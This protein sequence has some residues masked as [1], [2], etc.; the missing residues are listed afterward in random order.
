MIDH[1][2]TYAT[3]FERTRAF[4]DAALGPL[5][6]TRNMER[7]TSQDP[8][9][10]TRRLVAYGPPGR[11]VFWVVET[12]EAATPRHIAFV[13]PSREAVA[14]FH[15]GALQHGGKDNGGP[16]LRAHYH[17]DYYGAFVLDPDGNNVEA[18]I[19]HT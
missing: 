1:A 5:G 19:H 16:G 11:Y 6:Y 7:Q 9:W 10:P 13:A 17:P 4:Y 3:D 18:V 12:R 2:S 15:E 14:S 8:H